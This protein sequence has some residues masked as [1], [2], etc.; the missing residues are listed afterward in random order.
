M[1][2]RDR[3]GGI[4]ALLL[5]ASV[6]L[7]QQQEAPTGPWRSSEIAYIEDSRPYLQWTL[8]VLFIIGCAVAAVK[9]PHRSHLD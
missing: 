3:I 8:G 9:N 2:L 4:A 7:A 1:R 5:S 6:A